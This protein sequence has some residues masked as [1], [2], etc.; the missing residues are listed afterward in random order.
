MCIRAHL[1]TFDTCPVCEIKIFGVSTFVAT[2]SGLRAWKRGLGDLPR[3]LWLR[4]IL[5]GLLFLT[6]SYSNYRLAVIIIYAC[7]ITA[8][9]EH[10]IGIKELIGNWPI[11]TNWTSCYGL[12][13]FSSL[14]TSATMP[15]AIAMLRLE[16][17]SS[18]AR[19]ASDGIPS[20]STMLDATV[21]QIAFE[22]ALGWLIPLGLTL[23]ALRFRRRAAPEEDH[24]QLEETPATPAES[25]WYEV[26]KRD[27]SDLEL[28]TFSS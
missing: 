19:I 18:S 10:T 3:R 12:L 2:A 20:V 16:T 7:I 15:A 13:I 22:H 5:G 17:V 8:I 25:G 21:E 27:F 23:L 11:K 6:L 9:I 4:R 1:A 26:A 24:M 28:H 14:C